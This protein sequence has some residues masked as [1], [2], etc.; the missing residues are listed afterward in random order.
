VYMVQKGATKRKGT[1]E[2]RKMKGAAES[3]SSSGVVDAGKGGSRVGISSLLQLSA[4]QPGGTHSKERGASSGVH[5]GHRNLYLMTVSV[6]YLVGDMEHETG[7]GLIVL[8]VC[9]VVRTSAVGGESPSPS[10]M[11]TEYLQERQSR[12]PKAAAR[13]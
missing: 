7:D 5:G 4:G 11:C 8:L 2:T 3:I 1:V 12:L 6:V 13:L 9:S 10:V